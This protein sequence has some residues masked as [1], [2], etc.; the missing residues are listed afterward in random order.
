MVPD[1]STAGPPLSPFSASAALQRRLLSHEHGEAVLLAA[2]FT[3][4]SDGETLVFPSDADRRG[5]AQL[6]ETATRLAG[7]PS[8]GAAAALD[9]SDP[10]VAAMLRARR[11][12]KTS[13][14]DDDAERIRAAMEADRRERAAAPAARSSRNVISRGAANVHLTRFADIGVDT[15]KGG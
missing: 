15:N 1:P 14:Q 6:R 13:A 12:K 11:A 10:Q 8:G 2:G 5:L 3:R 4:S 7:A 9:P